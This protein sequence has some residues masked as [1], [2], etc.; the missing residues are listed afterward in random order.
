MRQF[1]RVVLQGFSLAFWRR[2]KARVEL[3]DFGIFLACCIVAL[4]AYAGQD[5]LTVD[6]PKEFFGDSFHLH[7][8]YLLVLL[9]AAWLSARWLRRPALWLTL[10]SLTVLIGVPWTAISLFVNQWLSGAHE[11]QL[12][13][14]QALL[15]LAGFVA[16]FR[17]VGFVAGDSP[18]SRRVGASLLFVLVLGMPWYWQ[19]TAW[20]WDV[21]QEEV[22]P[23][24]PVPD[25]PPLPP[26]EAKFDA[27][28][29]MTRQPELM[30]RSIEAVRAQTPGK[31]DLFAVGFAGDG[32]EKV[33]R[34][35]VEYF[36]KLVAQRFDASSRTLSLINSP[37]TLEKVPLASLTNLRAALA[38][39]AARMDTSEDILL[40]FLTS[41]GSKDH[42]LYVGLK[43]LP[44]RQ[45]RPRDLRAALDD[46]G[47]QWRV[48]IVSACYSGGFVDSLR[49]PR[50]LVIT[51]ARRDRT[52]F[53]C[54]ATSEITWF[55][56]AFLRDGLNQT[57][58]FERGFEIASKQIREW[59][60]A[61]GEKA[62]V[63]QI[64]AGWE[65]RKHLE[66]WRATVPR[67]QPVAFS[68]K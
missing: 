36:E 18:P 57:T 4:L 31:I 17:A 45:I 37:A 9:I 48:V 38:G 54:G 35:E 44:L 63:P 7:A 60:L 28:A 64:A 32:S 10:A 29:V 22:Q 67:S 12:F 40:L 58:D 1:L 13:A 59:E 33:F 49:D 65:I 53:G 6:P 8:S 42:R 23:P 19:L 30:R 16:I 11:V 61:D 34:N 56:K 20:F 66:T 55:G 52:S 39:V 5:Y 27:E 51:A 26:F 46:A 25:A 15:A 47:L 50:T 14:W 2:P 3:A 43:P 41:H 62:S 21:P 68:P 24:A